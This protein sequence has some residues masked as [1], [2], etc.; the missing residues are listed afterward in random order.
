MPT[1]QIPSP[2]SFI[3]VLLGNVSSFVK[4]DLTS[5]SFNL[6]VQLIL[7]FGVLYCTVHDGN[8]KIFESMR[9]LWVCICHKQIYDADPEGD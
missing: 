1:P 3:F 8:K 9:I 2:Y 5:P 4:N 7:A 6:T